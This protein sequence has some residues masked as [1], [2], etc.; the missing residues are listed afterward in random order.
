MVNILREITICMNTILIVTLSPLRNQWSDA[1]SPGPCAE[2][3]VIALQ[4]EG[5]VSTGESQRQERKQS[6]L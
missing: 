4:E 6:R 1:R 2:Q 3:E 5:L